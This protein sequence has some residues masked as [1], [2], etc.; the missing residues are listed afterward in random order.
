MNLITDDSPKIAALE[1]VLRPSNAARFLACTASAG[2]ESE[3]PDKV[4]S[5]MREGTIAHKLAELSLTESKHPREFL[6]VSL[7]AEDAV[8]FV[9]AEMVEAVE[10]Y[11]NFVNAQAGELFVEVKGNL[12]GIL[13]NDGTIDACKVDYDTGTIYVTDFKYGQGV[14]VYAQ[15]NAQ[16]LCYALGAYRNYSYLGDFKHFVLSIVQPRKRHVDTWEIDLDE[17]EAFGKLLAE[18]VYAIIQE[19]VEFQTGPHCRFC[20][21]KP[22]CRAAANDAVAAASSQF[23]S[24]V[25]H[26]LSKTSELSDS[27]IDELL[28]KVDGIEDWINGLREHAKEL[29]LNGTVLEHWKLVLSNRGRRKFDDET[30]VLAE[31]RKLKLRVDD[32]APRKLM[33]PSQLEKH[34]KATKSKDAF[35]RFTPFITQA[36]GKPT[37]VPASDPREPYSTADEF[38]D[39]TAVEQTTSSEKQEAR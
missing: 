28:A 25:D 22:R 27:E 17:L 20:R 9:N 11:V 33:T 7:E 6:G 14:K 13:P 18:K 15:D 26:T 31:A 4:N 1:A 34:C 23:N 5:Y 10:D 8:G 24:L 37:M 12:E 32:I 35:T 38:E 2:V 39:L 36:E 3:I 30:A 16:L 19:D 21:F 29:L